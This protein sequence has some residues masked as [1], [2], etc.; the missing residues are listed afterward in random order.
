MKKLNFFPSR[1]VSCSVLFCCCSFNLKINP[2]NKSF[3]DQACSVKDGWILTSFSFFAFLWTETKTQK[4]NLANIQPSWPHWPHTW[5]NNSPH[6][7]ESG[8]RNPEKFS[9]WNPESRTFF[10]LESGIQWAGIRNPLKFW[11]PESTCVGIHLCR[12]VLGDSSIFLPS[13]RLAVY[14]WL[15]YTCNTRNTCSNLSTQDT[16]LPGR[17]DIFLMT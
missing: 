16:T 7:T 4:K 8:I 15:F 12:I 2:F 14:L 9:C 6:V 5:L 11:N 13:H 1:T 3:I 10:T 17:G